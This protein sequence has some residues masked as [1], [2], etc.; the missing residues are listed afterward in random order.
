MTSQLL[1][2]R[3]I[4]KEH[5][6]ILHASPPAYLIRDSVLQYLGYLIHSAREQK[7]CGLTNW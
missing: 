5:K 1:S 3:R 7:E 2:T 6:N 4:P